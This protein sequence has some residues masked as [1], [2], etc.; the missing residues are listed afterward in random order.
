MLKIILKT[1]NFLVLSE[2]SVPETKKD[3]YQVHVSAY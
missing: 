1:K 2:V 3:V